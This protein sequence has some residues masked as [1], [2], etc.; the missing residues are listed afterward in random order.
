MTR[1]VI[2][3]VLGNRYYSVD[4]NGRTWKRHIDQLIKCSVETPD[5]GWT[6]PLVRGP[7][8]CLL[9]HQTS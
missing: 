7:G 4:V 2:T 8:T 6:N 1:G 9:L 3:G 5:Q